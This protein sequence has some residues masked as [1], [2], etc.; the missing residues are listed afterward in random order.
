LIS[1]FGTELTLRK[2]CFMAAIGQSGIAQTSLE[3]RV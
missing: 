3:D 1:A 2:V